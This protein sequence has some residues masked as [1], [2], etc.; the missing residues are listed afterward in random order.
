MGGSQC[1]VLGLEAL[2]RMETDFCRSGTLGEWGI[3]ARVDVSGSLFCFASLS[4]ILLCSS[5]EPVL[6]LQLRLQLCATT[7]RADGF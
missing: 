6:M 5:G 1:K 2:Q 7:L 4:F 3:Q